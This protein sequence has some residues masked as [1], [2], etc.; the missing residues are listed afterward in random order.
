ML[1]GHASRTTIRIVMP[2]MKIDEMSYKKRTK[3]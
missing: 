3:E 2:G 1:A